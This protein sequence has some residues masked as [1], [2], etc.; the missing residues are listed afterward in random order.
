MSTTPLM[1]TMISINLHSQHLD[2]QQCLLRPASAVLSLAKDAIP[3]AFGLD[4]TTALAAVSQMFQ[5]SLVAFDLFFSL[6]H[7]LCL[8]FS[9]TLFFIRLDE[10][11]HQG[12]IKLV[13][14]LLNRHDSVPDWGWFMIYVVQTYS[15]PLLLIYI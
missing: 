12:D 1:S 2:L 4:F 6:F 15:L 9:I 13:S 7:Y 5:R 11:Y 3:L 8:I 10:E 14:V